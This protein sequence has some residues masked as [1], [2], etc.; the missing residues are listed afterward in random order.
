MQHQ[1]LIFPA[2]VKVLLNCLN[3]FAIFG[4]SVRGRFHI[5]GKSEGEA[6]RRH[7]PQLTR[8]HTLRF[9]VVLARNSKCGKRDS[10]QQ[11]YDSQLRAV[12][13]WD[14]WKD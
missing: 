6:L 5:G 1:V 13:I 9:T 11:C 14:V 4:G 3:R 10:Q 2:H 12:T 7:I 8:T